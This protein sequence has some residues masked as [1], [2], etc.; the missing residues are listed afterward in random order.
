MTIL[1]KLTLKD[2]QPILDAYNLGSYKS[3][4][5]IPHALGNTNYILTTSKRKYILKI[6]EH[7]TK[8]EI[9]YQLQIEEYLHKHR[10]PIP[11][12]IHNTKNQALGIIKEKNFLLY[13]FVQGNHLK[14][15]SKALAI[16]LGKQVGNLHKTLLDLR[17]SYHEKDYAFIEFLRKQLHKKKISPFL[18]QER[19]KTLQELDHLNVQYLRRSIIHSDLHPENILAQKKITAFLDWGDVHYDYLIYDLG[20]LIKNFFVRWRQQDLT[21]F[22]LF[23]KHY[24]KH[25]QLNVEEQKA[26]FTMTKVALLIGIQWMEEQEIKHPDKRKELQNDQQKFIH[27]YQNISKLNSKM[28]FS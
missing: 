16:D 20:T 19:E 17:I 23:L 4:S 15:L 14:E 21:Y 5:H 7:S 6:F 1:T 11:R 8:K 26:I 13:E 18:K 12:I 28:L 22:K 10:I 25:I 2:L 27:A 24:Q 3:H 9:Q